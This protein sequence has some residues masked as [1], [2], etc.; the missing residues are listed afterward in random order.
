MKNV[1][2]PSLSLYIH[3]PWCIR[4]CPYCDFNSHAIRNEPPEE[5]YRN[6]LLLDLMNHLSS[7][8]NRKIQSIFIG[9]GTPSLLSAKFYERLFDQLRNHLNF[10][11]DIEITL[12]A[13]PGTVEQSRFKDYRSTGINRLSL[14][15]QSLQDDKLKRL[16]RIHS[17]KEAV[18]AVEIA[19]R[20]GFDNF[21]LDIMHG[22]PGQSVQDALF[23]LQAALDLAPKHLSWYQLTLEPNTYFHKFPPQLPH[24]D[25]LAEIQ[26]EGYT[27]LNN[28]GFE[29]YEVS[30]FAKSNYQCRHNINYWEFGDY[31]GIGAGAHSKLTDIN[32]NTITRHWNLKNP[33]DYLN[34]TQSFVANKKIITQQELALE[35]MMNAL[36]L[37][38]PIPISLFEQRTG[39]SLQAIQIPLNKAHQQKL[40]AIENTH[41]IVTSQGKRYLNELLELFL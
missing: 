24:D 12:E 40:L 13:N 22:L 23:D 18:H 17:G 3:T 35:F 29:H 9:G 41:F 5:N 37:Q 14:G 6:A 20:A 10:T 32:T 16:G 27:Q 11:S 19:T 33:K 34:A 2:T 7:I 21:N 15:I 25:L 38:K 8:Q 4:K 30:A 36:R 31:I 28:Y 1:T 26:K 39:L